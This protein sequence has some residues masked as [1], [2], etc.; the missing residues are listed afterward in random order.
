M[1]RG[2]IVTYTAI[3]DP[4]DITDAIYKWNVEE[5]IFEIIEEDGDTITVKAI[6]VGE[7]IVNV[8]VELGGSNRSADKDIIITWS[9]DIQ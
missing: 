5:D 9:I 1:C 3:T 8:I 2:Q 7:S 6:G 4:A